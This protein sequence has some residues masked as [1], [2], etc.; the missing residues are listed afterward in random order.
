M[1]VVVEAMSAEYGGIR[2]YVDNLLRVWAEDPGDD[3]LLLVVPT[4]AD[5]P[6]FGHRRVEVAVPGPALVGRPIAQTTRLRGIVRDFGA[7][8][9][10]ATHPTT[11]WRHTGVPTAVV[12]YDLRHEI[13]PEQF[14]LARRQIR[15]VSYARGYAV[16]D[17][18]I[19][20][21]QR[22]LDDLHR[23]HPRTARK[24]SVVAHLGADHVLDW[25]AP[26]SGERS[27][28]TFAHHTNKNPDLILEGWAAGHAA[29]IA[30]PRLTMLG[31]GGSREALAARVHELGLDDLVSLAPFLPEPE[32]HAV[33]AAAS[34]IVFPTDFEGFGLPV[35]EGMLLGAPVVIG[36]ETATLEVAGGHAAV[37]TDWTPGALA[38]A[39]QRAAAFDD[40]HRS[41]ARRH[42][43]TFTWQRCLDRTRDMLT[44]LTTSRGAR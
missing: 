1:R 27:A 37:M 32:F 24:P 12:I 29:G 22:S 13:R 43:A 34:M 19:A 28:V 14:S 7:D 2:T 26:P 10:L 3:E 8:A 6:D 20:I 31:T 41:A 44:L 9:L 38:D 5:V 23:L 42:A 35:V 15:T 33:M 39:V 36:P 40:A 18:F 21:S 4:G 25:P 17:G 16:A 11:S 30:M